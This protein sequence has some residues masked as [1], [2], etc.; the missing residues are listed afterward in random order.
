[1]GIFSKKTANK[2][3][4]ETTKIVPSV[5]A[6]KSTKATVHQVVLVRPVVTEKST[7]NGTYVFEVAKGATKNEVKKA[8]QKKYSKQPRKVNI[9]NVMGK[10]KTRGR[11]VGKQSNWK[12][13]VIYLNAGETVD[14]YQ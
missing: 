13:A 2:P 5:A 4:E 3:A 14:L 12:K 7:V 10:T 6:S 1:M 9:V 11:V 8:F